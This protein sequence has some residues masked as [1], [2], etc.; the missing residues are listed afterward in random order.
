MPVR[1][2]AVQ[3]RLAGDTNSLLRILTDGVRFSLVLRRITVQPSR[4]DADMQCLYATFE[5]PP[6]SSIDAA[7][8]ASRL[9]R[10]VGVVGMTCR[11]L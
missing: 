4:S 7:G 8:L 11:M 2:V 9:S 6:D 1:L 10:H 5:M 3:A